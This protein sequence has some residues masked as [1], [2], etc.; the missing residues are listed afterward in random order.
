MEAFNIKRKLW[1]LLGL[2]IPAIYYFDLF[3]LF[4]DEPG[5]TRYYGTWI[6]TWLVV[7][8]F[9]VE[10]LRFNTEWMDKL[11]RRLFA[12]I[13]KEQEYSR[14]NSTVPFLLANALVMAWLPLEFAV[15]TM[16]FLLFGDPS[17]AFFGGKFGRWRFPNGKSL[18]GVVAMILGGFLPAALF[19]FFHSLYHPYPE[20][21]YFF[22]F[23]PGVYPAG[24]QLMAIY[25][26]FLGAVL[27]A[28]A[29]FFTGN[30]LWGLVDDNL[31]IPL[32]SGFGMAIAWALV[33]GEP[34]SAYILSLP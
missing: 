22:N 26:V 9:V 4:S 33:Q 32:V 19:M 14:I 3:R 1:H 10:Y 2:I 11:F 16:L 18:V 28:L 30:I 23:S 15:L 31:T 24:W 5:V 21:I 12:R 8:L 6:L 34:W 27:A 20:G 7:F 17:A 29:E 25:V 13:M